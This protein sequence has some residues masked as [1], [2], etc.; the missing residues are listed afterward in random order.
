MNN[1]LDIIL[2]HSRNQKNKNSGLINVFFLSL[3]L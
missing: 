2:V 3:L 1:Y